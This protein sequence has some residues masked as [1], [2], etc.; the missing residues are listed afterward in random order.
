MYQRLNAEPKALNWEAVVCS[1]TMLGLWEAML[2][3]LA[4]LVSAGLSKWLRLHEAVWGMKVSMA[5][6]SYCTELLRPKWL[7]KH[8]T[9][10]IR[11]RGIKILSPWSYLSFCIDSVKLEFLQ[12]W[13]QRNLSESV[14]W[15]LSRSPI[16]GQGLWGLTTN[17]ENI[18]AV[19]LTFETS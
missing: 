1:S 3:C 11:W 14:H 18:Y 2:F 17:K 8:S 16:L 12:L 6:S 7:T 9:S 5:I 4:C 10:V 19:V 15:V 13:L